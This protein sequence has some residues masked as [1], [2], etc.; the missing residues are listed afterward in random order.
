MK[1]VLIVDDDRVTLT[2]L[3]QILSSSG[4]EVITAMDG[5]EGYKRAQEVKPDLLISDM[6][7]PKVDGLE[8]CKNIKES[9]TLN[10]TKVILM[11]GVY[12]G[13]TFK[14]EAKEVGADDF[15][16]KPFDRNSLLSRVVH[17]IGEGKEKTKNSP[18]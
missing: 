13:V 15:V 16:E 10:Q 12:K 6:L 1:K 7:I 17:L 11:T 14:V 5:E 8:L 9:P 18:D 2:M 4:Y 3:Q